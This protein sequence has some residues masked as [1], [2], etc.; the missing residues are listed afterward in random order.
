MKIL[1][2]IYLIYTNH[3]CQNIVEIVA[4]IDASTETW[5][6][7]IQEYNK[8]SIIIFKS[9][10]ISLDILNEYDKTFST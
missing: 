3:Q 1:E 4:V 10:E 2:R 6:C 7:R 5:F 9:L 8:I